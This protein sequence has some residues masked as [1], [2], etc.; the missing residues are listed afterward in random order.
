MHFTIYPE[1][2]E[3]VSNKFSTRYSNFKLV[4]SNYVYNNL[5]KLAGIKAPEKPLERIK[6]FN[7]LFHEFSRYS[8]SNGLARQ[9]V[10]THPIENRI[11]YNSSTGT[12]EYV[13]LNSLIKGLYYD[14]VRKGLNHSESKVREQASKSFNEMREYRELLN[15]WRKDMPIDIPVTRVEQGEPFEDLYKKLDR[16]AELHIGQAKGLITND[17]LDLNNALHH[18]REI[19]KRM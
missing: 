1:M 17:E 18:L 7:R 14:S 12:P 16:H 15:E 2:K 5:L 11:K 9:K 8:F 3:G 19:S 13:L 10:A 4:D 6:F